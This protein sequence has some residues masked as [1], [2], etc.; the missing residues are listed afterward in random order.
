VFEYVSLREI[1]LA[2]MEQVLPWKALLAQIEPHY[3]SPGRVVHPPYSM[4][5]TLHT[6]LLQWRCAPTTHPGVAVRRRRVR[7]LFTAPNLRMA[8]LQLLPA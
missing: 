2:E 8:R 1:F 7:V 4:Q 6:H 3:P 5:T